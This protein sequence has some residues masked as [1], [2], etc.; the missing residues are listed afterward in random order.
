M[1]F[2]TCAGSHRSPGWLCTA[3]ALA[4][5]EL[6]LL[7]AAAERCPTRGWLAGTGREAAAAAG[8]IVAT[9]ARQGTLVV[10]AAAV[11]ARALQLTR[12]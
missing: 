1:L 11:V 12:V 7:L 10:V 3:L 9:S 4:A 5:A 6:A 2:L 8:R